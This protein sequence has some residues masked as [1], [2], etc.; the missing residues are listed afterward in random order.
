[1][2]AAATDG[3]AESGA[4]GARPALSSRWIGHAAL[5]LG[6][7]PPRAIARRGQGGRRRYKPRLPQFPQT[8]FLSNRLWNGPME[9]FACR[10]V[11][12]RSDLRAI[13]S[14]GR[15][16]TLQESEIESY[17]HQDNSYIHC[18]PFPEMVSEEQ[19]I[20]GNYNGYHQHDVKYASCLSPHFEPPA[21]I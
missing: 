15:S 2:R 20:H 14:H 9:H 18:Q 21:Q 1:M 7:K 13:T 11:R 16:W 19:E 5:R 17:E 8:A 12:G 10:D 4:A 6:S 3:R